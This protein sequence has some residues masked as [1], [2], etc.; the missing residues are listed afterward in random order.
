MNT[1]FEA[2][3]FDSDGVLE[4]QGRVYVGARELLVFLA[5][6]Q[7]GFQILTNSTLQS[8]LSYARK[9]KKKGFS[10][11]KEQV[12]TA[13]YATASY[14]RER[15]P[16]S[17][18][19]MLAGEGR[20]EF[21]DL[22]IDRERPQYLVLGDCRENFSFQNMNKALRI[23]MEGAVFIVMIPEITDSSLGSLELTVGAYGKM[24][25]LASGTQAVY[26]GKP[27]CYMYELALK[28]MGVHDSSR[29]LMVGDKVK[30]DIA[31]ARFCGIRSA[32]LRTGEFKLNDL[33]S[34]IQP[35]YVFDSFEELRSFLE[36]R[37]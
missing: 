18:L 1:Q 15:N 28:R 9:M 17:V 30:T 2:V 29:V 19:I 21:R 26:I 8:R 36:L 25:E 12:I 33:D 13:S 5:E 35:D 37:V 7:V 27:N 11:T 20:E 34:D 22:P 14:I 6:R 24:L 32:L 4:Y 10:I 23:L 31:G 3:L 16:R